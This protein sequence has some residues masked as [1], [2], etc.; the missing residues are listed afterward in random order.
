M[1]KVIK[2]ILAVLL[3]LAVLAAGGMA[4]Y[5][6]DGNPADENARYAIEYPASGTVTDS[7]GKGQIVFM[8]EGGSR[9]GLV[10]YPGAK[11]R[12]DAYAELAQRLALDGYM[13]VLVDMPLNLA[14][15]DED[16]ADDV[17][18][19]YPDVDQW[20]I[21]GHSMGGLAASGYA[22]KHQ[23][24]LDGLIL[25]ASRIKNDFS[26]SEL[27]VLLIS[28]TEDGICT[29]ERLEAEDTPEPADFTHI[30]I[31]GGCHGYFG[32]YGEQ[33][34]DGT[35]TITREEQLDITAEN[36]R[37]FIERISN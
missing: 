16:A 17:I 20:Y 36:I 10:F 30:V 18:S 9:T 19:R 21:C 13:C 15:F 3:L 14:V 7:T 31:E 34:H 5:F 4:L 29:P 12:Y 2:R 37:Q 23:E 26:Q 24:A 32:S 6:S 25:L 22:L 11:V 28:A 8:P 33:K 35:P 1:G 27:P